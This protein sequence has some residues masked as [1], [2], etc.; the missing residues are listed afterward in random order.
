[1]GN[2]YAPLARASERDAVADIKVDLHVTS[3]V[4]LGDAFDSRPADELPFG[5]ENNDNKQLTDGK[6]VNLELS[7]VGT[8]FHDVCEER[9]RNYSALGRHDCV[10]NPTLDFLQ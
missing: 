3:H 9:P 2:Y 1:M 7:D 4:L 5:L 8:I 10:L 6:L